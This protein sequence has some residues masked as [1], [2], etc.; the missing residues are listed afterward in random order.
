M[1]TSLLKIFRKTRCIFALILILLM[2]FVS[3]FLGQKEIIIPEI[4]ALILGAWVLEKQ[5]WQTNRIKIVLLMT[6]CAVAGIY[7]VRIFPDIIFLKV[8]FCFLFCAFALY[9]SKTDLVPIIPTTLLPV[10]FSIKDGIYI[11][12]VFTLS[13]IIAVGQFFM[14][15]YKFKPKTEYIPINYSS[16]YEIKKWLKL[17]VILMIISVIP[18]ENGLVFVLAPPLIVTYV[19]F[20]NPMIKLRKIWHKIW[21]VLSFAAFMGTCACYITQ[22]Y[23][24]SIYITIS[25]AAI[26]TFFVFKRIKVLFPPSFA[27]LLIPLLLNGTNLM[28]YPLEVLI[29]SFILIKTA[30]IMFKK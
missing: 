14:E 23:N 20:S 5:M 25:F 6:V 1:K 8:A 27:M 16:Q 3:E 12:S 2:I 29:G 30:I 21:F 15:K 10:Y 13:L 19:M 22:N 17:L 26:I 24:I 18:Y 11:P 4:A 9:F 7:T 28:L